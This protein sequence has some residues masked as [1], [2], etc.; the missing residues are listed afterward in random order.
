MPTCCSIRKAWCKLNGSAGEILPRCDGTRDSAEIVADLRARRFNADRSMPM[1]G[2]SCGAR[3]SGWSTSWRDRVTPCTVPARAARLPLWLLCG[4]HLPCPLHCVFCYNPVDFARRPSS[5]LT[6]AEWLRVL[7]EAR[8]LGAVQLGLSGGEPLMR[9][10]LETI[11]AEAHG[12]AIY[13]NLITS[14]VGLTETAHQGARRMRASTTS[15]CRFRT[16]RGNSTTSSAARA[17]SS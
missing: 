11:V 10:D 1:C 17:P 16:R 6:T 8:A 9:D 2:V 3:A 12:S 14:G 4:T 13:T 7:R 15:S 5:E